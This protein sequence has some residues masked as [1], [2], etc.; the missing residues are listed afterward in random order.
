MT[1]E[2]IS[3]DD[4]PWADEGVIRA[5]ASELI[6]MARSLGLADLRY[7]SGNRIVVRLTESAVTF[8][9]YRFAE[10]A[11]FHLGY[12]IRVYD[13]EVLKNPGVSPDLVA[14]MPL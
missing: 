2:Y 11:S 14:A 7:A 6:A 12:Q 5:H 1:A 9:D 8:G 4:L 13:D 10:E 3:Y